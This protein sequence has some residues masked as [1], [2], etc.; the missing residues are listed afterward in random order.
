MILVNKSKL[1]MIAGVILVFF[2]SYFLYLCS[3]PNFYFWF[4]DSLVVFP[5]LL[6][7]SVSIDA[8][9]DSKWSWA[10][11]NNIRNN[12][13]ERRQ[14]RPI[15]RRKFERLEDLGWGTTKKNV[16]VIHLCIFEFILVIAMKCLRDQP[17]SHIH[18]MIIST[19]ATALMVKTA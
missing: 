11:N 3:L 13:E 14:D 18:K 16:V 10:G 12:V 6:L 8:Q 5:I 4:L 7:L 17:K 2:G 15:D 1:N 19:M 9:R